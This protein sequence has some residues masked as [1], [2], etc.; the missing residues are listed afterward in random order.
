[1]DNQLNTYAGLLADCRTELETLQA[2]L[3]ERKQAFDDANATLIYLISER[4]S[5]MAQVEGD[6]REIALAE[7][8]ATNDKK[9]PCGIG[10]RVTTKLEYEPAAALAWAKQHDM[11]L[12][13]DKAAFEKIAKASPPEFVEIVE[14]PTVTL[15][16]DTAK[17]RG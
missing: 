6:L 7:Y 16:T 17:L 15:P 9:L 13:L 10:I 11:A 4:K 1:M 8:A 12:T 2:E 5:A 14:V 3:Q